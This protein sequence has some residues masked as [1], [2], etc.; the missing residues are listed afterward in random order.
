MFIGLMAIV[1]E[2]GKK[3]LYNDQVLKRKPSLPDIS[4]YILSN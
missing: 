2:P 3:I 4:A 1:V